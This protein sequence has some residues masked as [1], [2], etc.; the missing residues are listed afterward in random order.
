[1]NPLSSNLRD[2]LLSGLESVPGT[3]EFHIHVLVSSPRK[4]QGL[5]P[6]ARPRPRAY[7]QDVLVLVSEQSAPDEPRVFTTAVEASVYNIPATSCAIFY[8]SKVDTTGQTTPGASSPAAAL[9]RSLLT[10]YADPRTRPVRADHLWIHLFARAQSQYL[11]PNSADWE[12]KRPLGDVRLCAWWKRVLGDV[13]LAVVGAQ[14]VS[15][16]ESTVKTGLYYVLPGYSQQEAEHSLLRAAVASSSGS[17]PSIGTNTAT[18][19]SSAVPEPLWTYG[20]PYSQT[21]IP[22]PCPIPTPRAETL[23]KEKNW[24]NLGHFIPSFDDDPKARFMDEIAYTADAE[25]VG[26]RSPARKRARTLAAPS[27]NVHGNENVPKDVGVSSSSSLGMPEDRDLK[28]KKEDTRILGELGK[29]SAEEYWE[30]MSFRQECVAGA[31]TGFF[32]AAFSSPGS[33]TG[34]TSSTNASSSGQLL[35]VATQSQPSPLAPQP[36]Q[37]SS[38]LNKRILSSLMTGLEFSTRERAVK[39]TE[40]LEGAIRGLCE[41]IP[42]SGVVAP[43]SKPASRRNNNNSNSD[44]NNSEA[45][46]RPSTPERLLA[47]PLPSTPPRRTGTSYMPDVSPN[48]FPEP[49][50]SLET[51]H[52]HIYGSVYVRN[53]PRERQGATAAQSTETTA[54]QGQH[55]TVLAVRR[56]KKRGE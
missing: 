54:G 47:P 50:T 43:A 25:G 56:K 7:L 53:P 16:G 34:S 18:S 11:F 1:M 4:F 12:G 51:Y 20:H 3:R 49:V 44:K 28:D 42:V 33:V 27:V 45:N 5:F 31:V 37:V 38:Q 10:F 9:V 35:A 19:T 17:A 23:N 41:G 2:F 39:A 22:L 30:R 52:S 26:L 29:V 55:V 32:V 40:T 36:G 24:H 14:S 48:P 6:F 15:G 8:V 21:E 13:A 46:K